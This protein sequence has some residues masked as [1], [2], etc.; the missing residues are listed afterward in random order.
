MI[1]GGLALLLFYAAYLILSA[2]VVG[3]ALVLYMAFCLL[4]F[5]V[6]FVIWIVRWAFDGFSAGVAGQRPSPPRPIPQ[7][8]W[9]NRR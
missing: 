5:A 8:R 3:A 4:A 2:L 9:S 7:S 1:L 6:A